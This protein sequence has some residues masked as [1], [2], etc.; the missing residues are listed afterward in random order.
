MDSGTYPFDILRQRMT[1][2]QSLHR[3]IEL[4]NIS[5]QKIPHFSKF[6]PCYPSFRTSPPLADEIRNP[7][8]SRLASRFAGLGREDEL[9]HSLSRSPVGILRSKRH[10]GIKNSTNSSIKRPFDF[11]TTI[12]NDPLKS[13]F[14]KG[15]FR[16]IS[17]EFKKLRKRQATVPGRPN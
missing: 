9:R 13:P 17:R 1:L 12:Q 14:S 15:G 4:V 6:L 7:Y 2:S 8:G 16:G 10:N 11:M 5:Q 3:V